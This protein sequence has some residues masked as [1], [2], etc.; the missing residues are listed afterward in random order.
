MVTKRLLNIINAGNL[1]KE[2]PFKL[3]IS[4]YEVL[5]H[6]LQKYQLS[7]I[8]IDTIQKAL[9]KINYEIRLCKC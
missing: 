5:A 9:L 2:S 1:A 8:K 6:C 3:S 4:V 7:E